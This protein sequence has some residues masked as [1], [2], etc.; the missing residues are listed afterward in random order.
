VRQ[1]QHSLMR[2]LGSDEFKPRERATLEQIRTVLV[3]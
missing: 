2:Y 3:E 1:F